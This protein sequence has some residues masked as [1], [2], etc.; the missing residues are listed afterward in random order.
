MKGFHGEL[1]LVDAGVCPRTG[2]Q[3]FRTTRPLEFIYEDL[4]F[5]IP[6]GTVT[7]FA[8]VP[9]CLQWLISK[10][11]KHTR[12]TVLHDHLCRTK[13]YSRFFS[14][15]VFRAAMDVDDVPLWRRVAMY[16]AVRFYA[17][18]TRKK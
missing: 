16:Y 8:S 9:R 14:D 5:H 18:I 10:T 11:G 7:D 4:R 2:V 17:V 15:A 13:R 1:V 12:S 6:A 3:L